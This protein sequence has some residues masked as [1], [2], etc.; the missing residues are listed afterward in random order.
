[1]ALFW[2]LFLPFFGLHLLCLV[3]ICTGSIVPTNGITGLLLPTEKSIISGDRRRLGEQA[4][5]Y[6]ERTSGFCT[7]RE[8]GSYIG[9]KEDCEEGAS[10]LGWSDTTATT[11]SRSTPKLWWK[12]N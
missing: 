11:Q 7:D 5:K 2:Y 1:M 8:G 3:D 6:H 4:S 12:G 9:T 10:V